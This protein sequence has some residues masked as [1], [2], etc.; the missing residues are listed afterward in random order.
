MT[1]LQRAGN[2]YALMM[3]GILA[4]LPFQSANS[5]D[6]APKKPSNVEHVKTCPTYGAGF[7]VVPGTTSC[8]RLLGR[9]RVEYLF[10]S[11]A[12]RSNDYNRIR[13]RGYVLWDH[14]TPTEYGLLR[15]NMRAYIQRDNAG[16]YAPVV[17]YAFIQFGGFTIGRTNPL[18]ENGFVRLFS[19][20]GQ[21]LGGIGSDLTYSNAVAYTHSFGSG[22]T[23]TIS[24]EDAAQRRAAIRLG[25]GVALSP[26]QTTILGG[27]AV[28]D[29]AV[30]VDV[31]QS[32]GQAKVAGA[33]HQIRGTFVGAAPARAV[34]EEY[35]YAFTTAL[36]LELPFLAKGSNVWASFQY[37]Q[38]A[39][40]YT[41]DNATNGDV[42]SRRL[43]VADA[44]VDANGQLFLS[45]SWSVGGA[46]EHF[47]TPTI[48]ASVGGFYGAFDARGGNN[49]AANLAI[50][51]HLSW[52]PVSGLIIGG[53]AAYRT[54]SNRGTTQ[55]GTGSDNADAIGRVRVQRDF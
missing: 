31:Q 11:P 4:S 20:S 21:Y 50:V 38:G 28:P 29:I 23:G 13:S 6:L 44:T 40:F 14:R 25:P 46:F 34:S 16:A 39:P 51:G 35:G 52:R 15:T 47:I 37:A 24:V 36:K 32:W 33:L 49:T 3:A 7:F 45:R 42:A 17:E 2:K 53:E 30:S 26:G 12:A 43:T 22:I 19:R 18:F 27:Q 10:D 41:H 5:A 54:I 55:L 1:R 9:V 8:L 48:V